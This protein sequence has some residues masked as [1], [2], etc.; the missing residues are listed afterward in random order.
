[1]IVVTIIGILVAI[2]IP[3]FQDSIERNSLKQAIEGLKSDMQFAR[4]EAIKK[5]SNILV[6]RSPGNAG[7]WCYGL[8]TKTTC[9]CT[10]ATKTATD[11]CEIKRV[12]GTELNMVNMNTAHHN[13]SNF[14][15]RRGTIGAGRVTFS[16]NNYSARVIFSDVGRVRICT[17]IYSTRIAGYP[18]CEIDS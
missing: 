8:S 14:S 11:Y 5:S 13:N 18:I 17:P 7:T 12:F 10:Q 3:S 2:A 16:T 1:M 4:T 6:T 15:F 9:T